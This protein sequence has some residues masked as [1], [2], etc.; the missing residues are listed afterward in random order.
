MEK[1]PTHLQILI[2]ERKLRGWSQ[3]YVA[4]MITSD[5][6]TV[7]RWERGI[8]SP[9]PYFVRKLVE[10]F[11][12][13]A[14][15]LGLLD[16]EEKHTS[17]NQTIFPRQEWGEAPQ[18]IGFLGR[19]RELAEFRRWVLIDRC[20]L[21]L[22]L[23]LG[24][25]GKTTF[26]TTLAQQLQSEFHFVFWYSLRHAPTLEDMLEKCI[27]LMAQHPQPDLPTNIDELISLLISY[28][29][30]HRSL[31]ILDN[32]ESVL[33][34]R[35]LAG[36]YLE[37]YEG[38]SKLLHRIGETEHQSCLIVTSREKPG[39]I[40][41]LEG[42]T[43]PVRSITLFGLGHNEGRQLLENGGLFGQDHIWAELISQYD[44]NPLALKLTAEPIREVFSGNIASF[45]KEG[46]TVFSDV[47]HLLDQQFHRLSELEQQVVYWL[48][49]EREATSIDELRADLSPHIAHTLLT[50]TLHSLRRRSMVEIN[51]QALF[52]LQPEIMRYITKRIVKYVVEEIGTGGK[53]FLSRYALMKTG[54]KDYVRN[55]QIIFILIP[56]VEWLLDT[57]GKAT[58]VKQLRSILATLRLIDSKEAGYAAGNIINILAQLQADFAGSDFSN[59]TIQQANLRGLDL[60][61]VNFACAHFVESIFTDTFGSILCVAFNPIGDLLAAGA[62]DGEIRLWQTASGTSLQT[63]QGHTG[64]VRSIAFSP[65]GKWLISG[66]EDHTVR[67]WDV[68]TGRCIKV[69]QA[70][71]GVI[72]SVA[73]SFHGRL[74]ASGSEDQTIRLWNIDSGSYTSTLRGHTNWIRSIAFSK[75]DRMIASASDD[76]SIIIW[77]INTG[78]YLTTLLG[79]T[80]IVRTISFSPIENILVS[81]GNDE[82]IRVWDYRTGRC[83]HTLYGHT[84]PI[85][86]VAFSPNGR[87]IASAGDDQSI[88][89]WDVN[90]AQCLN[91]LR[92]HTK[93][94]WSV[95]F[96]PDGQYLVSGSEDQTV[97][98]WDS[99]AG[100]CFRTMCGYSDWVWAIAFSPNGRLLASGCEDQVIRLWD[101]EKGTCLNILQAHLSRVRAVSFTRDGQFLASA[102]DDQTIRLWDM[103]TMQCQCILKG[104]RHLIRTLAFSPDGRLLVSGS[105]DQ[106][107]RLWDVKS[108]RC[109]KTL[110]GERNLVLGVA[111]SPDGQL[112]ASSSSDHSVRVWDIDTGSCRATLFGHSDQVWC[113]AFSPNDGNILASGSDDQTIRLWNITSGNCLRTLHGHTHWVRSIALSSDG[114]T[115]ASGSH[116]QTIRLWDTDTGNNFRVLQDHTSRIW[117]VALSLDG[118]SLACGSDNGTVILWNMQSGEF[119]RTLR[120]DRPYERMNITGVTGLTEVQRVALRTL[121]AIELP[122]SLVTHEASTST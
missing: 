13:S 34:S 98:F 42:K 8:N 103:T 54:S 10:L 106:T 112:I 113:V 86:S 72:R 11:G 59:L 71:S 40:S 32:F 61:D 30:E 47:Y 9:G 37:G 119:L 27:S 3:A 68:L 5:P 104:H 102:S 90:S 66:S 89:L 51:S 48:A 121:G 23:G 21:L 26:V 87:L 63:Y 24:G 7:S 62:A 4:E 74:I 52:T 49:I 64:G 20:R 122:A 12:K 14:E 22:V 108:G 82:T 50:E 75:D 45:L 107:I 97:R 60:P 55:S 84:Y 1:Q 78:N 35:N 73:T 92:E 58:S 101:T 70:H 25:I 33:H 81:G 116:D 93:R 19:E 17:I 120:G 41:D 46:E 6:K 36:Q 91:I 85:R 15:E 115:L 109:L 29:R 80:D 38:Y 67:C 56:I 57:L 96:S 43:L 110:E 16:N 83:L 39:Q 18:I 118:K 69:L 44:G 99:N 31:L 77:D 2:R 100:H 114:R 76:K 65:D 79:H 28:L 88:R 95:A 105:H 111:F 117:S 53:Q 94:V